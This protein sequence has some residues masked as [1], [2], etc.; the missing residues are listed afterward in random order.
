MTKESEY[1]LIVTKTGKEVYLM[2]LESYVGNST[3]NDND[4]YMVVCPV[5]KHN[6]ITGED[7]YYVDPTYNKAKLSVDKNKEVGYCFR[8]GHV[9]VTNSDTLRVR[10]P[11]FN[12]FID[13]EVSIIKLP[14][15]DHAKKSFYDLTD[16]MKEYLHGRNPYIDP[17]E[18]GIRTMKFWDD[19]P[20]VMIPFYWNNDM[21]YYQLRFTDDKSPKYYH[22]SI[23]KKPVYI[24]KGTP[25]TDKWIIVEGVF[26]A[27][28]CLTS[29]PQYTPIA[30]LGSNMTDYQINL[31]RSVILPSEILV[32]MDDDHI[33][34][35]VMKKLIDSPIA[36]YVDSIDLIHSSGLD[37]EEQLRYEDRNQE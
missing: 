8:G 16:S 20:N 34:K 26:D 19:R 15:L 17:V 24:P 22:P 10:M 4:H 29:Y 11:K 9:F 6:H 37:P 13:E 2:D 5:C 35:K 23:A 1:S 7:G 31:L 3:L 33:S 14:S 27:I 18:L 36:M 21:I 30:I 28:A 12:L 32:R 25:L